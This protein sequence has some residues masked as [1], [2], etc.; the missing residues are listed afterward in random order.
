MHCPTCQHDN[1]AN[2][3]FCD[4][5]GARLEAPC[6]SCGESNRGG[7]K[8]C[9]A[10]G[11]S[12]SPETNAGAPAIP[13]PSVYTPKHL[14][15]KILTSRSAMEGE[16][17]Q[18]TVLFADL[19]GSMELLADRDP[20][21]AR[22]ILDP[23]LERMMEAVHHFEGTVNQVMGDGIM[24][25]FG[26]PLA[27]ED[28]AVRAC[29]SALRMQGQIFRYGEEMQRKQ[30]APLQLRVGL[31][32][33]EVVVRAIGND[34][35]MDYSAIGQTTHLAARMEQMARPGTVLMTPA[36]LKLAEGYVQVR[37]LGLVN[38]KGLSEQTEVFE[39]TGASAART[40][41]QAASTR[42]L[43][44]FVGRQREV[45][46]LAEALGNAGQ[47]RGQVVAIVGE[48]GVGK[49]RLYYEFTRSHRTQGW[50][51]VEA[52]SV[53]YGKATPY[54]PLIDLLK[55]YFGIGDRDDARSIREKV[56]GKLLALDRSL[57]PLL[58]PLLALLD[59]PVPDPDWPSL[60]PR[61]RRRQTLDAL[62]RLFLR[63]AQAQ[64]LILVFEDLH[65]ID[66]ETQDFLDG[67]V[68][69]IPA[70]R[71]LL[72]FNYRPEYR[73]PW[74]SKTYYAQLRLDPLNAETAEDLLRGLLGADPGVEPLKKLLIRRTE[75]NPLFLEESVRTLGETGVL[76][77]ERG[78]YRLARSL[79]SIEVPATVQAMLA[80]RIDRLP[81]D[82]KRLLQAASVIGMDVPFELLRQIADRDED[83]LRQGLTRL[84]AAEFLYESG[85]FPDLECTFRHALMHDVA[86]G[87]VLHDRQRVLHARIVE[88]IETLY[89]DRLAEQVERLAHHAARGEVW[90]KAVTY[91][92][93]AGLKAFER[94][95]N[96]E[97]AAYFEQAIDAL[98]HLPQ[99][100]DTT[101]RAID[102]RFDLR[103]PL[104][105]MGEF[106]RTLDHLRVAEELALGLDDQL[107]L[108][109]ITAYMTN[110]FWRMGENERALE[111][112]RR[113]MAI[114]NTQ[115]DRTLQVMAD[116]YLGQI[117]N[118]LGEYGPAIGFL[119]KNVQALQG[120][121]LHER[122][123]MVGPVS[124]LSRAFLVHSLSEQ[125]EFDEGAARGEEAVRIAEEVKHPV[126]LIE[127]YW[128]V[129]SLYLRKGDLERAIPL[130]ERGVAVSK[131]ANI[132]GWFPWV[133]APLGLTYALSGRVAEGAALLAR[134]VEAAES[135][136]ILAYH[137]LAVMYLAEAKWLAGE[138][139]E[140]I[141]L[142]N[143]ALEL[144]RTR[145]E[146]GVEAWTLRLLGEV[147]ARSDAP[148]ANAETTY[149]EAMALADELGMRPLAAHCRFGLGKLFAHM[150]RGDAARENLAT[151]LS[152]YREMKMRHW[153][154]QAEA[155]LRLLAKR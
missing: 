149:R 109:R 8:F 38:I 144:S 26:A 48:P 55:G 44:R 121:L 146:R 88:A 4:E 56:T 145:K 33:G 126:T 116:H 123:G 71:L 154:E 51:V 57:E 91:L 72:L 108:G 30:G 63:E 35:H 115:D 132:M 90:D 89:A 130:L 81:E 85:L 73:H 120:D 135:I 105:A 20:E 95:A 46:V 18:V 16:R 113:L 64:P 29:Y 99:R 2:A 13:K 43:T 128:S 86:Y 143:R 40:R 118:S 19:K 32:S 134:A 101:E 22:K 142:A 102:L 147:G 59:Q 119:A 66:S 77:G 129:G 47:A 10:C 79:E 107:R 141:G 151:A 75:G 23:V 58:N 36:T 94:S 92:R 106:R 133:A 114:A 98:G 74:G 45:D 96:R 131:E 11:H 5:C 9:G 152:M 80:A 112:G 100:R 87:S 136:R 42:G 65:W 93:Q 1:P 83:V 3:A 37:P 25:L 125:G 155:D 76:S 50:L 70:A 6:P 97:A 61:Q 27:H 7:A 124:A 127:V 53:S 39:L 17:K 49:S 12:L 104:F 150:G 67:L 69:R 84:Q 41:L 52:G 68:E 82:D 140:A 54:L 21:E 139:E 117:N 28:H 148:A 62:A 14:A 78:D 111:S 110:S 137:S 103:S 138:R 60:D 153:P 15:D 122:F 34:L 31:N 24:A